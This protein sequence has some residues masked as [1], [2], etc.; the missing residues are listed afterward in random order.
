MIDV[1]YKFDDTPFREFLVAGKEFAR[2]SIGVGVVGDDADKIHPDSKITVGEIAAINEFGTEGGHI[3]SRP[4]LRNTM[5]NKSLILSALGS[6]ARNVLSGRATVTE[7]LNQAGEILSN[8]VRRTLLDGVP[9][10]NA[11]ATVDWKGHGDTLIGL[12]GAL[13]DAIS[14]KIMGGR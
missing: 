1:K 8:E 3:P 2:K 9:P 14:H 5:M 4:F 12:T 13:Y 6:A 11:E 10:P 7:A